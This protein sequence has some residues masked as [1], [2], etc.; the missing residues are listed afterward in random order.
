[1]NHVGRTMGTLG[2]IGVAL[3]AFLVVPALASPAS[4][5]AVPLGSSAPQQWAYGAQ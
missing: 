4:A 5:S 3:V 2:V 1:M